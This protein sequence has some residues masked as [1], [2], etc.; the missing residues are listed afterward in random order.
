MDRGKEVE[1]SRAEELPAVSR[2]RPVQA[3]TLEV[4]VEASTP[5]WELGR[6]LAGTVAGWMVG[7][8]QR[9]GA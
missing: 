4:G 1:G 7:G 2:T 5:G 8:R 3:G 6:R 9:G